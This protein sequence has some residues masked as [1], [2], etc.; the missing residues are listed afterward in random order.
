MEGALFTQR[1]LF[2]HLLVAGGERVE[3]HGFLRAVYRLLDNRVC[4][5][6]AEEAF[7]A[8]A[9][10]AGGLDLDGLL[11]ALQRLVGGDAAGASAKKGSALVSEVASAGVVFKPDAVITQMLQPSVVAV[12]R[13]HGAAL[14]KLFS[15]YTSDQRGAVDA[16]PAAQYA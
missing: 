6:E 8:A 11:D 2:Q 5:V 12:L 3:L 16:M 1:S 9:A 13:R 10:G 7:L 15:A 14:R 4:A